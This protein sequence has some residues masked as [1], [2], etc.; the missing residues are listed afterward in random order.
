MM[1]V[2]ALRSLALLL[3]AAIAVPAWAE[4]P[5][6]S[7]VPGVRMEIFALPSDP[8]GEIRV[9]P[10][11]G[12]VLTPA[13]LF[14]PVA[15][16]NIH[17]PAIVMLARGPASNPG[18]AGQAT[19]WAAER[20][21]AKGYTVLSLQLHSDRSWAFF[22]FGECVFEIDAALD[23]L[24]MR[25][26]EDFALIGDSYGA[27]AAAYYLAMNADPSL[28]KAGA[29]RVQATVLLNPLTELRHYPGVDLAD[30]YD[31][32]IAKA[33][34]AFA[35]GRNQYTAS[36]SIEVG[37]GPDGGNQS[38]LGTGFFIAPAEGILNYWGP[39]ADVRNQSA[40]RD[41]PVPTLAVAHLDDP[42]VSIPRLQAIAADRKGGMDIVSL[43][44]SGFAAVDYDAV[45]DKIT[46]WLAKH[47]LGVRARVAA[48][49]IDVPTADG[50]VLTAVVYTP[51]KVDPAKPALL[52]VHG[53][54]GEPIQSST[55]W[56]GWRFAQ[57]GY[58]VLSPAFRVSGP[59]GIWT[60]T[61]K[62]MT[63]DMG[64]WMNRL[65]EM[66]HTKV[67]AGGHSNGGIWIS[68]YVAQSGDKRIEGI[69]YFAP[70]VNVETWKERQANPAMMK[71][72]TE[73]CAAVKAGKGTEWV[74]GVQS[75]ILV[76]DS[77]GKDAVSHPERLAKITV[78]GLFIIGSEDGLFKRPGVRDRLEKAYA[79][80]LETIIY[81]GGTHGLRESKDRL[82]IDV[83][84]WIG[85]TFGPSR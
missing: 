82:A 40:Y 24:E 13:V 76:C 71:E 12:R 3:V 33:Q 31:A 48:S 36:R 9:A 47:R 65:A 25:G 35:T 58:V 78:P 63:Q 22:P 17:G 18:Y 70:T 45:T 60:G 75:A 20:L 50:S 73:A 15:G 59:R 37:G 43:N 5:A 10:G 21:A 51:E 46:A 23:A 74:S 32:V 29:R 53:R 28:D 52:L 55:H 66:G 79:G 62:M 7:P 16:E 44:G 49:L 14:T 2:R 85:K 1:M 8:P 69:V 64:V 41:A 19:R 4:L 61:R 26:Y 39:E 56:M 84:A 42:T 83:D 72:M 77:L 54:S 27:A 6:P 11:G 57:Q 30:D 80:P 38:W 34:A 81:E 67:I 68:D